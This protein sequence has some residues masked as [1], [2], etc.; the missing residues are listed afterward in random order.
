[1]K[2]AF[3]AV[4]ARVHEGIDSYLGG[5]EKLLEGYAMRT[6]GMDRYLIPVR[7]VRREEGV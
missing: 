7:K 1:L 2:E 3:K 5:I 4:K 6:P